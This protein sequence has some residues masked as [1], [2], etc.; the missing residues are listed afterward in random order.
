KDMAVQLIDP[1]TTGGTGLTID[2]ADR[3]Y[4]AVTAIDVIEHIPPE[5]RI[6]LI[7]TIARIARSFC[8]VSFP[9]PKTIEAQQ[10]VFKMTG[11]PLVKEHVEYGLP[12]PDWVKEELVHR[13]FAV[14][15][16]PNA[17][18][19]LWVAQYCVTNLRQDKAQEVNRFLIANFPD[20]PA[21]QHLYEMLVATR[22]NF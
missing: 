8:I 2:V 3:S 12:D 1:A 6:D 18:C 10:F 19:A 5:S 22:R 16:V 15:I 21:S 13:G 20:E 7:D 11:N 14:E 9:S 4:D 17:S